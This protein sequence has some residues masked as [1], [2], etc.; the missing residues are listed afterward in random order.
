MGW[1]KYVS[2]EA[3]SGLSATA[4]PRYRGLSKKKQSRLSDKTISQPRPGRRKSEGRIR[5]DGKE[6]IFRRI[7]IVNSVSVRI[8]RG[9]LASGQ[10]GTI[11][12]SA[13]WATKTKERL[14]RFGK[15]KSIIVAKD[16]ERQGRGDPEKNEYRGGF[17]NPFPPSKLGRLGAAKEGPS[18]PLRS[19]SN[20]GEIFKPA[21]PSELTN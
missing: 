1:R 21:H 10:E 6:V 12:T 13:S 14:C 5:I 16:N 11:A 4:L 18:G 19:R 20:A 8:V 7:R 9:I 3:Y 15:E 2:E 17:F